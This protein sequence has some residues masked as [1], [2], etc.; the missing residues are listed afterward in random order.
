MEKKDLVSVQRQPVME[1][2]SDDKMRDLFGTKYQ[3]L[4]FYDFDAQKWNSDGRNFA[5]QGAQRHYVVNIIL[6][7]THFSSPCQKTL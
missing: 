7:H 2:L 3:S 4:L 5:A 6:S 1:T